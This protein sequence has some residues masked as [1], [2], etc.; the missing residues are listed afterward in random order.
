MDKQ[1]LKHTLQQLHEELAQSEPV[2]DELKTLLHTLDHD[3]H[4]VLARQAAGETPEADMGNQAEALAA[5][6]SAAYPR[7]EKILRELADMLGKMGI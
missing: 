2:D 7:T 4:Q 5:H 3:I 6:F 1:Q